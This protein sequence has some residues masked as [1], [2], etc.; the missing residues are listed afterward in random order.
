MVSGK[1][2]G[3]VGYLKS[4]EGKGGSSTANTEEGIA[5]T[6]LLMEGEKEVLS[7]LGKGRR[8]ERGG[9]E[10]RPSGNPLN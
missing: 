2:G 4:L 3:G 6:T 8:G 1:A 9:Y 5:S 10:F 7:S